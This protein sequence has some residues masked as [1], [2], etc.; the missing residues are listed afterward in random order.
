MNRSHVTAEV[1][2]DQVTHTGK[3]SAPHVTKGP[4][5]PANAMAS[6]TT[7]VTSPALTS[8]TAPVRLTARILALLPAHELIALNVLLLA[9]AVLR[10]WRLDLAQVG[11]DE[12]AAASLV[13]A[14]KYQG[15]FPLT[16]I[17]SSVQVPNPPAWP[18]LLGLG[19]LW[20]DDP[21]ALVAVGVA[22]S[23]ASVALTWWVARRWLGPAGGLAAIAFY[24][25]GFWPVLLGRGGWQ[26]VFLQAPALLCLDAL[27]MLA[28][29]RR[30]WALA[31]ASGWLALL[32]QL[33]YVAGF[34]VILLPFAAWLARRSLRPIHVGAGL[35]AG[36]LPLLP[37]LLY[38]ADPTV[39]LRDLARLFG[40]LGGSET[41]LDFASA[42]LFW[43]VTSTWGAIGLGSPS[44]DHLA[45]LLGRW[46]NASMVGPLLVA[47]GLVVA[48]LRRPSGQV[49]W[50]LVA[51]T[52]LPVVALT[53]HSVEPLFHHLWVG[54]PGFAL[55]VGALG[56]WAWTSGRALLRGLVG[57][58]LVVYA[59]VSVATLQV[60]LDFVQHADVHTGYGVP[61]RFSRDA[62]RAA[63]SLMPLGGQ[64]LVGDDSRRGEVLRFT[65]GYR[66]R[67]RVFNDCEAIPFAADAVY[68]L[69]SEHTPGAAALEEAGAPLLARIPRPG[70]DAYSVYGPWPS[71]A[72]LVGLAQRPERGSSICEE[73]GG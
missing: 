48:A 39:R 65:V 50:I 31:A 45:S 46:T 6:R 55:A 26:P 60:V 22:F 12:S 69:M 43:A 38:E 32:V 56:A 49:G 9:A 73:R 27:L 67:S 47:G 11:Y 2:A 23:I 1:G 37:F 4:I 44:G 61:I 20:T 13:A 17:E 14:W 54:F 42:S 58:A 29:R 16:G 63:S 3:P 15:L 30:P 40:L 5:R 72:D 70:S 66:N 8:H 10:L 57:T 19:L 71:R 64:V 51:W 18:Y 24:G 36:L 52:T 68:L 21:Y 53:R 34:Y 28:V 7:T 62:G 41:N 35:T 59:A 25:M 33:H